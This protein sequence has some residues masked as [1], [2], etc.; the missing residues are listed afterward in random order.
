MKIYLAKKDTGCYL[1][2]VEFSN[3]MTVSCWITPVPEV[4]VYTSMK[5]FMKVRTKERGYT[6]KETKNKGE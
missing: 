2:V 3:G 4:A 5:Q 6:V 1:E